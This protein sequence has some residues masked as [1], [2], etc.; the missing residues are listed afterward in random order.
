MK[1]AQNKGLSFGV[2]LKLATKAFADGTINVG[3]LP[4]E[5]FNQK[6]REELKK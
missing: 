4:K 1:K 3:V 2:V 6:T 5:S